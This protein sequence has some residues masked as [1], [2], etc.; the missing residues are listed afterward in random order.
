MTG[1]GK[2]VKF[3]ESFGFLETKSPRVE[4]LKFAIGRKITLRLLLVPQG[5]ERVAEN[6]RRD[7]RRYP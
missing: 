6:D 7:K 2:G 1:A 3:T 4:A 5:I